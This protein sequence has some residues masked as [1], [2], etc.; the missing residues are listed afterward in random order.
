MARRVYSKEEADAILSRAIE[1]QGRRNSTTHEDLVAAGG[2]VGLPRDAID[3]AADELFSKQ[4]DEVTL[5][6]IRARS[7]RAF[8]AHLVPYL[9]VNALLAFANVLTGGPPWMLFVTLG[10][11]IGLASHL[12]AVANPDPRS[13]RRQIERERRRAG[14]LTPGVRV[15]EAEARAR[16][17]AEHDLVD[18][19]EAEA[20]PAAR[21]AR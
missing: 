20:P 11:G 12:F 14:S 16:V 18:D 6:E 19:D 13:L 7:W 10:W 9:C 8:Y 5:R 21:N 4:R 1:L 15:A 2:E 3:R 17:S